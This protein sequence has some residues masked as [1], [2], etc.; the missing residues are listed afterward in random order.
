MARPRFAPRRPERLD[1]YLELAEEVRACGLRLLSDRSL[2]L[3][4]RIG[5]LAL[6]GHRLPFFTRGTRAFVP[7]QRQARERE[8]RVQLATI[9]TQGAREELRRELASFELPGSFVMQTVS[10]ALQLVEARSKRFDHLVTRATREYQREVLRLEPGAGQPGA[11]PIWELV[12]RAYRE[13][14]SRLDRKAGERALLWFH[15]WCIND[16]HREWYTHSPSLTSHAFRMALRLVTLRFLLAGHPGLAPL[17]EQAEPD[18][19]ALDG[20][21]VETFQIFF[22]YVERSGVLATLDETLSCQR[23]GLSPLER[24]LIFC[25]AA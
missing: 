25:A 7:S 13:R 1:P 5:L 17:L 19:A 4:E 23:L 16:W 2:P 3:A 20:L 14:L 18:L 24:A 21:A 6:L 10:T 11:P 9:S 12:W 8:L 15:N 22:K